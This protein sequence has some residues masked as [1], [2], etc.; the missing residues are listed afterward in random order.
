MT[1]VPSDEI[2]ELY[3]LAKK[4]IERTEACEE[5]DHG[6]E[7]M[8]KEW[9]DAID[10]FDSLGR[11]YAE[12]YEQEKKLPSKKEIELFIELKTEMVKLMFEFIDKHAEE[13]TA[14][15]ILVNVLISCLADAEYQTQETAE[16]TDKQTHHICYQIGA[17]YLMMKPLLEGQHNLG[18][19]KER[20]KLMICGRQ[21]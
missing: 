4:L 19:M 7:P 8:F 18:H 15:N 5:K 1:Q 9:K 10:I 14:G 13:K 6:H 3:R 20:L 17:W 11:G 16:F 21:N 2:Y 12:R